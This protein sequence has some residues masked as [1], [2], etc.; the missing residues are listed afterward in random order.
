MIKASE[1]CQLL[2]NSSSMKLGLALERVSEI[3]PGHEFASVRAGVEMALIDAVAKSISVPLWI[4][5]GGASDCITTDIT[6]PIVSPAEA[7][8]LG[9]QS[10][11]NKI[12]N[13]KVE[14]GKEP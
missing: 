2:K 4:L 14:G 10:I 11:G 13:F 9:L 12:P 6:I 1:A 5:F 7:A 8:E 3:L